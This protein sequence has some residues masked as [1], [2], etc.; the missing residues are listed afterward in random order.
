VK[1]HGAG[2]EVLRFFSIVE[3]FRVHAKSE[4]LRAG[5]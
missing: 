4:F 5:G 3:Y 1:G 2:A